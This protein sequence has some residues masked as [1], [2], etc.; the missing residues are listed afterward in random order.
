M[1]CEKTLV[2]MNDAGNGVIADVQAA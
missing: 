2:C 1:L